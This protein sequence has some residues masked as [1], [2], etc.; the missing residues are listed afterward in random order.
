[1]RELAEKALLEKHA[2]ACAVINADGNV[3]YVHGHTGRY[4]E[5]PAGEPTG[6]LLKM[7]RQ[8]LRLELVSGVRKV[9]TEKHAVRYERLQVRADDGAFLVNL[10][11]EPLS[12]PDAVE[13]VLLVIFED[14]AAVERVEGTLEPL[15]DREQRIAD[16]DRELSVKEEFLRTTVEQLET[17]NEELKSANEEMQSTN[18]EMQSTNEEME[19][20]R[21]ELQSVNEELITVNAELQQTIQELNLA[22]SDMN[23]M[24]SGTGIGT[25]FVDRHLLIRRFTPTITSIMNLIPTDVGRP[26][27]DIAT[28]PEV[29]GDLVGAATRVLDTLVA[30]ESQVESEGRTYRMRVQPYRTTDNIIE[31]AVI[32]FANITEQV[33]LQAEIDETSA[34]AAEAGEF[35]QSV[36][37]TIREPQLVMDAALTVVTANESFLR[38]YGLTRDAVV[39][40]PLGELG[41]G[42]W[43]NPELLERLADVLSK[44]ERLEDWQFTSS[45]RSGDSEVTLN[46]LELVRSLGKRRMVLLTVT[47]TGSTKQ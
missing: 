41:T 44:D 35:A 14:V 28:R 38:I 32:T 3:L 29:G 27:G 22:N 17:S 1:V 34:L 26:L 16:L 42:A 40:R 18:E 46:A 10:M 37:D 20:S 2:P 30:E 15:A 12:G 33:R 43:R 7:A 21:E 9:L 23:N 8:G 47:E 25:L 24:L 19:T 13:G 6:S 31:G 45:D 36:L 11:I 4:L 5:L 39:G